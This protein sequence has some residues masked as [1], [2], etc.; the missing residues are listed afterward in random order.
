V[1]GVAHAAAILADEGTASVIALS[2]S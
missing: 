1:G 2:G